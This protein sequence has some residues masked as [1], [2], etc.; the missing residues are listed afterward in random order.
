MPLYEYECTDCGH[1]F[2]EL[3]NASACDCPPCPKCHA[4][5]GGAV[6]RIMSPVNSPG[7]GHYPYPK[8]GFAQA[9]PAGGGCGSGGFQ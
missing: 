5:K 1:R 2:E 8:G 4:S 9:P 3:V 6:K 7:L